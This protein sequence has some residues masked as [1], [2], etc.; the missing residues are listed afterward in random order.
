MCH[1]V[2]E[3]ERQ[4]RLKKATARTEQKCEKAREEVA[5]L[6]ALP[7]SDESLQIGARF[8]MKFEK[9]GLPGRK[10]WRERSNVNNNSRLNVVVLSRATLAW[11]KF[12]V[13]VSE[14]P[15]SLPPIH[16]FGD[17]F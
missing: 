14:N 17:T 12:A 4:R 16:F 13:K 1:R 11:I 8:N 15:I 5:D 9:L 3:K 10:R 7:R 2:E 6:F